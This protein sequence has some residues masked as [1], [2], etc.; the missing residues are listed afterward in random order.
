[1]TGLLVLAGFVFVIRLVSEAYWVERLSNWLAET[2]PKMFPKRKPK[3]PKLEELSR[4]K[5][6]AKNRAQKFL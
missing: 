5:Q 3:A 6:S 4:M 2:I 1:M